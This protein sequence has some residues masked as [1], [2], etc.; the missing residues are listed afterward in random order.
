MMLFGGPEQEREQV[1]QFWEQRLA[2]QG[3]SAQDEQQVAEFLGQRSTQGWEKHTELV[4]AFIW[5]RR[6]YSGMGM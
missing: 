6:I 3:V 5:L 4:R 2:A 1:Q